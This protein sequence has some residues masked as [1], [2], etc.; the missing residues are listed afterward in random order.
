ML[1]KMSLAMIPDC[2]QIVCVYLKMKN[3][4]ICKK[5]RYWEIMKKHSKGPI[6]NKAPK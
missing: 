3:K 5:V 6:G 1:T 2:K 4:Y